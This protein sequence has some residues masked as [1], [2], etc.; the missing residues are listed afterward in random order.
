MVRQLFI[1][2]VDI[3]PIIQRKYTRLHPVSVKTFVDWIMLF[4]CS[5]I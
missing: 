5:D 4:W 1:I 3:P 2:S